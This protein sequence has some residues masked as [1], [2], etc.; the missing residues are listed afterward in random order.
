MAMRAPPPHDSIPVKL[1]NLLTLAVFVA[2][3]AVAS[4]ALAYL[5]SP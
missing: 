5:V 2:W 4:Y 3:L 1:L